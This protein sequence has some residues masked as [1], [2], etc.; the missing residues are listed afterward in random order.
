MF[1]LSSKSLSLFVLLAVLAG[2]IG[3]LFFGGG[4]ARASADL[5][6]VTVHKAS[7]CGCCGAWVEH[8]A[9]AGFPVEV[10]ND[11]DLGAV[12][13][14]HHV[15]RTLYACHTATVD[16]YTVE[17]HVPADDVKRMLV[18]RPAVA[19][20]GVGGMPKGAPGMPGM[21]TGY[22]IRSF[23]EAGPAAVWASH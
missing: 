7:N 15:P 5:P 2:G 6:V 9:G 1:S 3:F 10:V 20:I 18:E 23:T 14:T 8:M 4:S 19:G 17:G 21:P 16:G 12:K 11:R 22:D 13:A